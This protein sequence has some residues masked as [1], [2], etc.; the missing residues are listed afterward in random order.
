MITSFIEWAKL[1]ERREMELYHGT[2]TGANDEKLAAFRDKGIVPRSATGHGQGAGYYTFTNKAKVAQHAMDLVP[3]DG[4]PTRFK[5]GQDAVSS[6]RHGGNPMV[7]VHKGVLNPRD[8]DYDHEIH[9]EYAMKFLVANVD[10]IN[11]LLRQRPATIE[12]THGTGGDSVYYIQLSKKSGVM[13]LWLTDVYSPDFDQNTAQAWQD[14]TTYD[15]NDPGG[16][17]M[18]A[19]ELG[20]L[21]QSL[22]RDHQELNTAYM[23]FVRSI[24]KHDSK[25]GKVDKGIKYVGDQPITPDRIAVLHKDKWNRAED[26][27]ASKSQSLKYSIP[28][29]DVS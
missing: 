7:V 12:D 2:S 1:R 8:Y 16:D 3:K 19:E 20:Q 6:S 27:L 18:Q 14:Y 5:T 28:A 24:Q 4:M 22:R 26:Y 21:L 13:A 25:L 15:I 9:P 11:K 17:M 23:Q 29:G 10:W